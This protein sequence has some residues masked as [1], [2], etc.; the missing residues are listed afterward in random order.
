MILALGTRVGT[1]DKGDKGTM[2]YHFCFQLYVYVCMYVRTYVRTGGQDPETRAPGR[3]NTK[4]QQENKL[5][6]IALVINLFSWYNNNSE[7]PVFGAQAAKTLRREHPE[8]AIIALE[9][10]AEMSVKCPGA[11]NLQRAGRFRRDQVRPRP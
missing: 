6:T 9:R 3:G 11:C 10:A 2:L 7:Q 1:R 8:A 5:I 4:Q